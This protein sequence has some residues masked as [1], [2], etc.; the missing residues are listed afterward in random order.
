MVITCLIIGAVFTVL[1]LLG[2]ARAAAKPRPW[3]RRVFGPEPEE[4]PMQIGI[5]PNA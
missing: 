1:W 2:L 3:P 4:Q 5:R